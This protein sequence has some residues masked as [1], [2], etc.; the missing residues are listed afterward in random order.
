M[1]H[2]TFAW[3]ELA[4]IDPRAAAAF[5][6]AVLGWT[7]EEVPEMH[8]MMMKADGVQSAGVFEMP[9]ELRSAG[10]PPHWGFYV[11]V[12]DVDRYAARVGEAGGQV[13]HGPADIPGIGRFA[14]VTDPHGA[15]FSL[16]KA[17]GEPERTPGQPVG[18]H[19]LM[20]KDWE[21]AFGFYSGLFGWT[22][23]Q[24]MD[25]GPMGSY[26]LFAVDGVDQGGMMNSP[27]PAR[28]PSWL[29]YF[30]VD[31]L[32]AAQRRAEQAGASVV[33]G[34][35]EVPG[36]SWIVQCRDP[37]GAMFALVAATR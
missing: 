6:G 12:E 21:A 27:D 36:G 19:E 4:T 17:G 8:Y 10:V 35:M 22:R 28:H 18:W 9:A 32:D 13:R 23:G 14:V 25:M 30:K 1:Q 7:A 26:Q 5:Y 34:P 37:Q 16:F 11:G 3:Y 24:T 20:T 31:G 15:A 2:G 33:N 29:L